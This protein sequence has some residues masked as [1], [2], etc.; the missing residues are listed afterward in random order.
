MKNQGSCGSC[1]TFSTAAAIESAYLIR[2]KQSLD[3]SEQQLVDCAYWQGMGG[4]SA[5]TSYQGFSYV[6]NNGI[7]SERYDPYRGYPFTCGYNMPPAASIR[8]FCIRGQNNYGPPAMSENLSDQAIISTL[9]YFGPVGV[10]VNADRI[11][12]YRSGIINDPYC[13]KQVNHAV[14][15]VGYTERSFIIKNSWGTNWV[16]FS[17]SQLH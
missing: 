17:H 12:N 14:L 11:Q 3:L 15:L 16:S 8:K 9:G 13:S 7:T 1:W 4:C 2:R 10:Y 5:G 6:L